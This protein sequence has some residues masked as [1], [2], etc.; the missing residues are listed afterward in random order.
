[1]SD[2]VQARINYTFTDE[3]I[4]LLALSSAH[5]DRDDKTQH[6]E[7]RGLAHYGSLVIEMAKTHDAIVESGRTLR[8]CPLLFYRGC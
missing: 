6:D 1:M 7:N 4:L 3:K 5:R 8:K 2:H